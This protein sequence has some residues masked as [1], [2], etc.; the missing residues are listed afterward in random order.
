M[1]PS[2]AVNS[3]DTSGRFGPS[4]GSMVPCD[5]RVIDGA[6]LRVAEAVLTGESEAVNKIVAALPEAT[7]ALGDRHY[8]SSLKRTGSP[9]IG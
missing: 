8:C 7:A 6:Q 3:I 1:V 9:P 2:A 5:L 4:A